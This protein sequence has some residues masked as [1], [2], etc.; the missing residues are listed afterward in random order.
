MRAGTR[1]ALSIGACLIAAA[2]ARSDPGEAERYFREGRWFELRAAVSGQS[3]DI[4]R[5]AVATAFNETP[6]AEDLLRRILRSDPRG[7]AA[8]DAYDLL[9]RIYRRTGQ[10]A[11]L[12]ET[13]R[14]WAAAFPD[15]AGARRWG[16]DRDKF[17][18]P[19][20]VNPLPART[21]LRHAGRGYP[22]VP[23]SINGIE[24]QFILD[25]GAWQSAL[26]EAEARK[27]GLTVLEETAV[28]VDAS[29]TQT[30]FRTAI[31][32]EVAI[33]PMRFRD[34]SFAVIDP[35]G[36]FADS[37]LG[38]V[39]MPMLLGLGT[40]RWSAEGTVEV[41]APAAAPDPGA[42]PNLAF[43]RTRLLLTADVLGRSVL[44][45]LDT[46]A[47]TTE[48]NAN[49]ADLFPAL[50][51]KAGTRGTQQLAGIGGARTYDS[52]ALPELAF[53]VG[54]REVTLRPASVTLQR[55]ELL[56]GEC[57]IGNAGHDLLVQG[58]GFSIDFS[59]MTVT[60]H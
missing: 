21:V 60:V 42:R 33:G 24:D 39:G 47:N 5:A 6:A 16:E 46:G 38:I 25:T 27:L 55:L 58:R 31:A 48:L 28:L 59:R 49:F 19:D 22:T 32:E 43:D 10:Y 14:A 34:V 51:Q 8:D 29:G 50:V 7:P 44:A 12:A 23:V 17:N 1:S 2:C 54:S 26:T 9:C 36:P 35:T 52:I 40:I 20:Q 13:H 37:E 15:S 11:R 41:G 4:L 53:T 30:R 45:T 56:G 18:R 3:P 57:C